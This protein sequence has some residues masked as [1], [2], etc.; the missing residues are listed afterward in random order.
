MTPGE[1]IAHHPRAAGSRMNSRKVIMLMT[2]AVFFM[3]A[4][5]LAAIFGGIPPWPVILWFAISH[6]FFCVLIAGTKPFAGPYTEPYVDQ[7][8]GLAGRR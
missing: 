8:L 2:I 5:P 7:P 1:I 3:L 6:I 4:G